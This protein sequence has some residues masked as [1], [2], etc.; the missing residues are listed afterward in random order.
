MKEV[1]LWFDCICGLDYDSEYEQDDEYQAYYQELLFHALSQTKLVSNLTV[2]NVQDAR[3]ACTDPEEASLG[4]RERLTKH[5]V[6]VDINEPDFEEDTRNEETLE[7]FLRAIGKTEKEV[8]KTK[9]LKWLEGKCLGTE[10]P[11]QLGEVI[12]L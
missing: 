10:V 9:V 3:I 5:G 8:S 7:Q 11:S 2:K 1:E 6:M 12:E 4:V